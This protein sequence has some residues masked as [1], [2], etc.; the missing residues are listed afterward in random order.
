MKLECSK[1]A[2]KRK[3]RVSDPE[4]SS[5]SRGERAEHK[6]QAAEHEVQAYA[7]GRTVVFD[8]EAYEPDD[9]QVG[10]ELAS[11]LELDFAKKLLPVEVLPLEVLPVE[12]LPMEALPVEA[13]T[14]CLQSFRKRLIQ[15]ASASIWVSAHT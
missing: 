10:S 11:K 4:G 7:S 5:G 8:S 6:V 12:V 15:I 14:R 3:P 2:S 13:A 1:Q 9:D